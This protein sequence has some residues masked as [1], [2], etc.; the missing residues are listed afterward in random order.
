MNEPVVKSEVGLDALADTASV[1]QGQPASQD[2]TGVPKLPVASSIGAPVVAFAYD[3][4]TPSGKK[5]QGVSFM[6][7]VARWRATLYVK[8]GKTKHL[9]LFKNALKTDLK[10]FPSELTSS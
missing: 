10:K 3:Q 7:K 4:A 8:G 9:G 2:T 1:K 5:Y 6:Y